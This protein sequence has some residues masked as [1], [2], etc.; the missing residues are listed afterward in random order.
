MKSL[1]DVVLVLV[2]IAALIFTV[3]EFYWF[4]SPPGAEGPRQHLILAIV[5]AAVFCACALGLFLRHVNKEEEIH[6]TQ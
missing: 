2:G 3:L 4:A 5:G 6:I 1:V